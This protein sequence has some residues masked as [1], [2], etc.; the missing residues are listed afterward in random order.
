M[1]NASHER[2]AH[3]TPEERRR[4]SNLRLGVILGTVALAFFAGF[5]AKAVLFGL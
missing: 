2:V 1:I 3:M 5:I 4:R